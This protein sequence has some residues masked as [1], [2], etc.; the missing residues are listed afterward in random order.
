[1]ELS[2]IEMDRD[3]VRFERHQVGNAAHFRIGVRIRPCRQS[4]IT[5]VVI[6]AEPFVW[7]EGLALYGSEDGSEGG[8]V[9]IGA[10][11]VPARR[12]A[13]LVEDERPRRISDDAVMMTDHEVT[14]SLAN[15]DAVIAVSGMAHDSFV[16]F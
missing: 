4:C 1:M 3:D 11:D 6:A 15:V 5:D 2:A 10:Q 8:L 14:G 13:G 12:K 9:D 16:F 7:A